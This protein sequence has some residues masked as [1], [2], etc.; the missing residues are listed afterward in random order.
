[1]KKK[2]IKNI[3]IISFIILAI[4]LILLVFVK[5]NN[6]DAIKFKQEYE[7]VN[8][9]IGAVKIEIDEDNP[10]VYLDN[11]KELNNKIENK[12]SFILYLGFPT[13]PWCRNIIPVLFDS[14]KENNIDNIY[15]MNTREI[16]TDDYDKLIELVYEYLTEDSEG[17]K[18]LYVPD[19]YFFNK[20][21]IVG[22]HLGSV[23]S[24][25]DPTIPLNKEQ[26]K[27]LK[28]IYSD[29]IKKIK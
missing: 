27:E 17:N 28:G 19:V 22:N 26:V 23:D 4:F 12:D 18:S 5:N 25:T 6:K 24:Q 11:Y 14:V 3:L 9:S 13:C 29:L 10:I 15:Y 8:N 21:N 1:M 16:N 20:G 7:E 2:D